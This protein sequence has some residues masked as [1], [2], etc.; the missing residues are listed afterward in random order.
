MFTTPWLTSWFKHNLKVC[1][2]VSGLLL[3]LL[4]SAWLSAHTASVYSSLT[5][6]EWGTFTSIAGSDG[7]ALQWSPLT[8]STDLPVFVEHFRNA[9]FK[10]ALRGTVRMETPVL[11]FYSPREQTVSVQ[12]HFAKGVITEW[13]PRA[14]RIEPAATL[15]DGSVTEARTDGSIAWDS[16]TLLPSFKSTF[17]KEAR[18][19]HYYAA[20]QTTSTPLLVR[21]AAGDQYEK[22]LFYRGVSVFPVP[23]SATV[24]PQA[25]HSAASGYELRVENHGDEVPATILFERRGEKF[26]YRIGGAIQRESAIAA[27]EFSGSFSSLA[28]ELEGMLV[29]QGLYQNEAQAMVETWRD[30]WF[31]EG[32]R[33]LYIVPGKFLNEILPLAINPAPEQTVRVFVGRLE[34]VTSE[35]QR[36]VE[37][38]FARNDQRTLQKYGRFLEPILQSMINTEP[39][40]ARAEQFRAHLNAVYNVQLARN[41]HSN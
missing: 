36:V 28:R 39:D 18:E 2:L 21:T 19:N 12:V 20:R 16:V 23:V 17:L 14:S 8:G 27:P 5:V 41:L 35:T 4:S 1:A 22:F 6:H 37:Q 24:V 26:G 31:E 32:S 34:L 40:R 3:G 11:Y 7:R 15:Y 9:N 29:G 10:F 30:S 38:A 13:Y 33:L 25:A